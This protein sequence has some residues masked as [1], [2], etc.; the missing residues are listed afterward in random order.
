MTGQ[1]T[2]LELDSRR[3][4]LNERAWLAPTAVIGDVTVAAGASVFC[5]AVVRA[6]MEEISIGPGTNVQF[7]DV[8]TQAA[9]FV[10]HRD[11]GILC[12]GA[13]ELLAP[14]RNN[15]QGHPDNIHWASRRKR[16]APSIRISISRR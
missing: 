8:K 10:L 14:L 7:H 3:P 5:G 13:Q 4:H 11:S 15:I 6:D 9:L 1:P 12:N 2:I 16:S